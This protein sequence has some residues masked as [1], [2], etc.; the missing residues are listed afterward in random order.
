MSKTRCAIPLL[1]GLGV[2]DSLYMLA[3]E[4]RWIHSLACPFFGEGCNRVGRSPHARHF[5]V[6]NA[7]V[8]AL[9]YSCMAGLALARPHSPGWDARRRRMLFTM[10]LAAAAAGLYLTWEQKTKVRHWCFWCLSSTAISLALIPFTSLDK[11]DAAIV[12][13]RSR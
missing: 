3:Y 7:L 6:P 11:D 4:E 13:A 9:G 5:G 1:A 10:N 8:G 12:V 2:L